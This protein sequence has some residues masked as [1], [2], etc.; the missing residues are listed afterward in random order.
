MA[1][2]VLGSSAVEVKYV[3]IVPVIVNG[4]E[5]THRAI[6]NSADLQQFTFKCQGLISQ[7][8]RMI[9][10]DHLVAVKADILTMNVIELAVDHH[11]AE[12]EDDGNDKLKNHQ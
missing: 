2:P 12:N 10:R 7:C 11:G 9:D 5:T 6:L 1:M 4:Q 3:V 8:V